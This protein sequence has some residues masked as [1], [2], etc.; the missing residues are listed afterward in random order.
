MV[1][2]L[3]EDGLLSMVLSS[4]GGPK[5]MFFGLYAVADGV[6]GCEGGEIASNLALRVLAA[7]TVN[8]LLL[9]ELMPEA[10]DLNKEF[11]LQAL[12][13]GVEAANN[14][15]YIQAQANGNNMGTTLAAALVVNGTAYIAN[16]GDSRIYLLEGEQ[17]RQVTTEHSLVAALVAAGDVA[18]G[19]IY[20]HPR[21]NIITRCLGAQQNLQVDLFAETLKPGRSLLLC[22]DG[23]WEMVRDDEIRDAIVKAQNPKAGCEQLLELANQNGGVDNIS[24]ILV[25][26]AR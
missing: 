9:P 3:N 8:S 4:L 17:L 21:R 11:A 13:D 6:G 16:V 26:I 20:T 7:N 5:G 22:S 12:A 14:E 15:V 25:K 19:E 18:P 24:V 1:R 23:L 2:S 10:H